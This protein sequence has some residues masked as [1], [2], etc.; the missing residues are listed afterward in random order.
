MVWQTNI[1]N[2]F[3]CEL[4]EITALPR[5]MAGGDGAGCPALPGAARTV[6]DELQ[7]VLNAA[8]RV[9]TEPP[10]LALPLDLAWGLPSRRPPVPSLPPNPGYATVV[11]YTFLA[12]F[13]F[14]KYSN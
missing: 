8:A 7:R 4:G 13:F 11:Q 5:H 3:N 10:P 12:G 6:T 9:I 2:M 1:R 14:L